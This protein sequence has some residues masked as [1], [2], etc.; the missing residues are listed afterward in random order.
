MVAGERADLS[1]SLTSSRSSL[2]KSQVVKGT[3]FDGYAAACGPVATAD[4]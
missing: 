2:T 1:A 4:P 3:Y